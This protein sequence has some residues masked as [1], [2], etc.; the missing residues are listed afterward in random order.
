MRWK[1][2]S[3]EGYVIDLT[4]TIGKIKIENFTTYRES[5]PDQPI[6]H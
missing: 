1:L 6:T 5:N 3:T 4:L 2:V